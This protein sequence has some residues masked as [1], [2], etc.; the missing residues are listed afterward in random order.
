M[1]IEPMEK[2]HRALYLHVS[3]N[4][5]IHVQILQRPNELW[6]IA[7]IELIG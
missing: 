6:R 2:M 7:R 3:V 1:L 5:P 4:N